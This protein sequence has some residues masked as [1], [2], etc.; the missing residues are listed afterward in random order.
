MAVDFGLFDWIDQGTGSLNQT[1]E[2]R[3]QLLEAADTAGF[4]AY[5]LA[6]H[7]GTPL[8][9]APSPSLFLAAAA[10][11]TRQIR[12]GPLT[13]VLPLYNP[14]RLADEI[15]MLDNLSGGRLELGVG[16]GASPHEVR[17]FGIDMSRSRQMYEEAMSVLI[18]A[19]TSDRIS[20]KGEHYQYESVPVEV[21]PLQRPYPPLWYPTSSLDSIPYAARH[22]FHFAGLGPASH[23]RR[24]VDK[25]REVWNEHRHD[26]NRWNAHVR[27]PRL[28]IMRLIVVAE[29]DAEGLQLARGAHD[30]WYRSITKLWHENSDHSMD[31]RFSWDS[32]AQNET[33]LCGSPSRVR[34]HM[35][36]LI[37]TSACNY[38]LCVF[39]WGGLP[40][41]QALKSMGLFV[42]E[43]MPAFVV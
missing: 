29:T 1:Y 34:N 25:Y 40:H 24:Q 3:L 35:A 39:A 42:K 9:L 7:H 5:H 30:R 32:A 27:S 15:A 14:L 22:G 20:F 36:R 37:E 11:R 38:V 8:G 16:R 23:V 4:F 31:A 33:V 17:F 10:Q 41:L 6:E 2:E 28:G 21:H 13:Y 26:P 19:M 18:E 12:L 43:V